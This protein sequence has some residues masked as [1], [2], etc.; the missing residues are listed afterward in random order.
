MT[1]FVATPP[2]P[3]RSAHKSSKD[4]KHPHLVVQH[5]YHDHA[6]D[7]IFDSSEQENQNLGGVGTLKRQIPSLQLVYLTLLFDTFTCN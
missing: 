4:L 5:N 2:L 7:P 3:E 1:P 6:D